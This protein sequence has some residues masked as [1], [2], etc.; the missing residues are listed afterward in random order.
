[1]P[2]RV[3]HCPLNLAGT[4]WTNVRALRRKGVDARLVV[5]HPQPWRPNEY[6][7]NLNRP[8]GGGLRAQL[9]QW[10][11]L[12][13]LLPQTDIFHFYFGITLVPKTAQFPILRAARKKSVVHWLGADIR[14]RPREQ[15]LW[16]RRANAQIVGSYA[17]RHY[18]PE[19]VVIQPGIELDR[20]EPRP[21]VDRG[22]V[23]VVHAPSKKEAKGTE[24]VIAACEQLPVELDVVHGVPNEEAL[25]RYAEADIVV[26]QL[27]RDWH[28]VFAIEAMALA[29]PVV[30]S[31][32]EEAIRET[33]EAFGV[34]V[35]IVPATKDDLV[36]KLRPLVESAEERRRLGEAGRAYVER[37][38]DIDRV[39]DRLLELYRKL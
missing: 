26:D 28:G 21:P 7:I 35:P 12:F 2:L 25:A 37:V 24:H 32:D 30:T 14:E 6:D 22:R 29:K 8:R 9:V 13:R 27:F 33:E 18:V 31:L 10:R 16:A 38:H 19:A 1:M 36:E 5:F 17:A 20:F 3:T 11:A 4:G 23:R 39:T 34:E 15:L